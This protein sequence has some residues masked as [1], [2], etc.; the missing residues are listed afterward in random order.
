MAQLTK[1]GIAYDTSGTIYD[2]ARTS[3]T[4][5]RTFKDVSA[6]GDTELV[7]A[8]GA[9]NKIRVI[10]LMY[11]AGAAVTVRFKSSGANNL[12]AAFALALN[13]SIVFPYLPHGWFETNANENFTANQSLAIA[14]GAQI[15]W[16]VTT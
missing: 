3:R 12:S 10:G 1:Y 7:A 2:S 16:I 14:S 6:I 5:N 4:V 9:G 13:D 11:N 8:Q 15:V